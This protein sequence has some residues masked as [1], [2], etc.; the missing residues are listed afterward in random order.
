VAQAAKPNP[1]KAILVAEDEE[2]L[3][4]VV[5]EALT[6]AGLPRGT[7]M[8]AGLFLLASSAMPAFAQRSCVDLYN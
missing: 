5:S 6:I 8:A 1:G 2:D 3:R 7:I 4:V